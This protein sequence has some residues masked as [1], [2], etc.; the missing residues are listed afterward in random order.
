MSERIQVKRDAIHRA[1]QELFGKRGFEGTSM[2]AIA[3]L[4]GVSKQ[5][6]YRYYQNK[7]T[8]FVAVLEQL[9]FHQFSESVWRSFQEMARESPAQLEQALVMWA[10]L[11]MQSI[12]HPAYLRLLRL[13]IAELPRFPQLRSLFAHAVLQQGGALLRDVLQSAREAGVMEV[14]DVEV[15]IRLLVGPLLTYVLGNGLL[16]PDGFPQAPPPERLTALVRT[17]LYGVASPHEKAAGQ[18]DTLN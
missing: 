7:E 5:T 3:A 11:T 14:E 12:M 4:A 1:A 10:Q 6:V 13:L 18:H 17:V 16:A 15:A 8:L 9:A 2:D